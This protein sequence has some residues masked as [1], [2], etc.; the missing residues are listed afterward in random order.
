MRDTASYKQTTDQRDGSGN[1][2]CAATA[3]AAAAAAAATAAGG[4]EAA[5][6]ENSRRY[7]ALSAVA[8]AFI[9]ECNE[10]MVQKSGVVVAVP[11]M[12]SRRSPC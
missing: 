6:A 3:A 11:R 8:I 10:V 2:C 4:H 12:K 5:V 9:D 7:C 1:G